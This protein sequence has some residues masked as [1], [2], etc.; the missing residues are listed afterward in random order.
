MIIRDTIIHGLSLIYS[1]AVSL[2]A[3]LYKSDLVKTRK[4]PCKVISVGNITAG[5]TG[6]TPMTIYLATLLKKL[7][8]RPLILS[9]GYKGEY[10]KS[11]GIVSNGRKILM[12][13][14]QSGDEPLMM[15]MALPNVP[16]LVGKNRFQMGTSAITEFK[17]DVIL[18]DDG[19]QHL[20][21]HRDIDLLLLDSRK[22]FDNGHLLPKGMLR[23]PLSALSRADAFI[24][25]RG[26]AEAVQSA[27]CKVQSELPDNR[28]VFRTAH[29]PYLRGKD[30]AGKKIFAFSGIADN[31]DFIDTLNNFDCE[32]AGFEKFSD[33]YAYSDDDLN[34]IFESAK[35]VSADM[36]VT[37]EK[38]YARISDRLEKFP[39]E[40]GI[41]GIE[42]SFGN[43]AAAFENFIIDRLNRDSQD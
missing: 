36:L 41:I 18:L 32:L 7:G 35:N 10:E 20:K 6:K 8:Y 37:T 12:N 24:F 2:R 5:G 43:D 38:D 29:V 25:T 27:K 19:F 9:R 14:R 4:L 40:V 3:D 23:E 39:F 13:A 17:P 22:P 34:R 16:V 21:L 28:P 11:G 1:A 15:A 33:H 26:N 42:I 30:I 31:D